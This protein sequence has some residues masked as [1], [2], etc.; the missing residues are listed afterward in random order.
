MRHSH[1]SGGRPCVQSL[2][3][4][5]ASLQSDSI[6]FSVCWVRQICSNF[7]CRRAGQRSLLH[8]VGGS[9]KRPWTTYSYVADCASSCRL[10]R[11][12]SP[13]I[14]SR[15][16]RY[17]YFVVATMADWCRSVSACVP[18]T[19]W[20]HWYWPNSD[21]E[22]WYRSK[23]SYGHEQPLLWHLQFRRQNKNIKYRSQL[24]QK[25]STAC[26][27]TPSVMSTWLRRQAT[28]MLAGFDS[29]S[30]PHWQHML[31][32]HTQTHLPCDCPTSTDLTITFTFSHNDP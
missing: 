1:I 18:N 16:T 8:V 5:A 14:I 4:H 2:S 13:Q 32:A 12:P 20:Y 24:R 3:W 10:R 26:F 23:P 27:W 9:Y 28:H 15:S 22:Y 19:I 11:M 31:H 6:W 21:T 25:Y 29:I 30:V 17:R 7:A